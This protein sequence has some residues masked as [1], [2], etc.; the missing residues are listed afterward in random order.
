MLK[1]VLFAEFELC[2][3]TSELVLPHLYSSSALLPSDSLTGQPPT[4][5]I[6]PPNR[7]WAQPTPPTGKSVPAVSTLD[8]RWAVVKIFLLKWST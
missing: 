8:G 1:F 6:E 4:P 7:S 2:K 5:N 3:Q